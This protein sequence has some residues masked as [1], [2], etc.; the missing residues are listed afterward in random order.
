MEFKDDLR[1]H[2]KIELD[3]NQSEMFKKYYELLIDY[4]KH[5]NLT[6]I[7]EENEVYYKH[8]YDSLTINN[9]LPSRGISLCDMGSGAGFP[10]IPLKIINP[11]LKITIIDSSNKRISF[12]KSL[13]SNLNLTNVTLIHSRI[14][15]YGKNH[16]NSFDVITARALGH[17]RLISEMAVPMLKVKGIFIAMKGSKGEEE[18]NESLRAIK[19]VGGLLVN[20][21]YL[22]LPYNLGNRS[23]FVIR[24]VSNVLG[25]PRTY[26]QMIKKPL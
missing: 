7:T 11:D 24:K 20:E 1:E 12:L 5:T 26:Q 14:E 4:N 10:S 19:T 21:K 22:E 25:Y 15:D 23:L 8:F 16:L 9:L 2:F 13:V 6:T 3:V 18:L 17:L